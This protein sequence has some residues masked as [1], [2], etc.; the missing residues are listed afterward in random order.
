MTHDVLTHD[1]LGLAIVLTS[2]GAMVVLVIG[3]IAW[4]I[5]DTLRNKDK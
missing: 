1:V 4:G 5:S 3:L 2:M